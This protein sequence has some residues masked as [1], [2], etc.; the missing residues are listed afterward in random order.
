MAKRLASNP[1]FEGLNPAAWQSALAENERNFFSQLQDF[2][3]PTV[4]KNIQFLNLLAT[5]EA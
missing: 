1:E 2:P 5:T 4:L 3:S